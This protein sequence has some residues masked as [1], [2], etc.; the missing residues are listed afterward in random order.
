MKKQ[1]TTRKV[2][3]KNSRFVDAARISVASRATRHAQVAQHAQKS[4][5]VEELVEA[6]KKRSSNQ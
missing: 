1:A 6:N 4:G 3:V 5:V 2:T